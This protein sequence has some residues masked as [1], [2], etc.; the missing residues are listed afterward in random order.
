MPLQRNWPISLLALVISLC[1]HCCVP[2][3]HFLHFHS[4]LDARHWDVQARNRAVTKTLIPW[5]SY[6]KIWHPSHALPEGP[7]PILMI[8]A[9][10]EDTA[11]LPQYKKLPPSRRIAVFTEVTGCC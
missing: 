8:C 9:R 11:P 7:R 1:D 2:P 3:F 5:A 4:L 10:Q 6:L